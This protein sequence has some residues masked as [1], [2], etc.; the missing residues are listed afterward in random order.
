[1]STAGITSIAIA[2]PIVASNAIFSARRANRGIEAIDENPIFAIANFDLAAAQVL[3]GCRAAKAIEISIEESGAAECI[4]EKSN[5]C[6]KNMSKK[7][8]KVTSSGV[9]NKFLNGAKKVLNFTANNINPIIIGTGALKV[10]GAKDKSDELARESTRITTMFG[11]ELGAK[12]LI[13]M[14]CLV[15]SVNKDKKQVLK[16]NKGSLEKLFT[17]SQLKAINDSK[18]LKCALGTGKGL[19]FVA[20]SIG[21]YKLGDMI[22]NAVL[23]KKE[24]N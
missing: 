13:G 21:G 22:G 20:A 12:E 23:G 17:D 24:D 5:Q 14:P 8:P 7:A 2:A 3:K 6:K 9:T 15:N 1:M 11:F 10:F 18:A 16:N 4:K 19:F